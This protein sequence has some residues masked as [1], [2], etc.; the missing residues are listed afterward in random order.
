MGL[1]IVQIARLDDVECRNALPL[2]EDGRKE[3]RTNSRRL[4]AVINS[5]ESIEAILEFHRMDLV[6]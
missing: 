6:S 2:I 3:C 1:N 4:E 5:D